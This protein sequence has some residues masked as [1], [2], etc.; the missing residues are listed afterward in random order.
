MQTTIVDRVKLPTLSEQDLRIMWRDDPFTAFENIP[1]E[2]NRVRCLDQI[3]GDGKHLPHLM[4]WA[5]GWLEFFMDKKD[6]RLVTK[7]LSVWVLHFHSVQSLASALNS[8]LALVMDK[9][10]V[11]EDSTLEIF[12]RVICSQLL[13]CDSRMYWETSRLH[14]FLDLAL[15]RLLTVDDSTEKE[16]SIAKRALKVICQAEDS[17]MVPYLVQLRCQYRNLYKDV[18]ATP[19]K[20][21]QMLWKKLNIVNHDSFLEQCIQ[22][23]VEKSTAEREQ[24]NS[25]R[26]QLNECAQRIGLGRVEPLLKYPQ[27]ANSANPVTV[28]LQIGRIKDPK[29]S[30][31]AQDLVDGLSVTFLGDGIENTRVHAI[32]PLKAAGYESVGSFGFDLEC[33]FR[34]D[35]VMEGKK[36]FR[37]EVHKN[38]IICQKLCTLTG[39]LQF[40]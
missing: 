27:L 19:V 22:F 25:F 29:T 38:N 34:L 16:W 32:H 17:T 15:S 36:R 40:E 12:S 14:P 8:A 39:Y 35:D 18:L 13:K 5:P 30:Q 33:L 4:E 26:K 20:G 10:F 37:L 23:L 6:I 7:L 24:W 2:E 9:R 3:A 31:R 1:T 21:A 28:G 11:E